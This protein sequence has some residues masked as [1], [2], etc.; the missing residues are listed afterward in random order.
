MVVGFV[1]KQC[2]GQRWLGVGGR[3]WRVVKKKID[4]DKWLMREQL[5]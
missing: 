2:E 4:G 5:I 3:M 1:L